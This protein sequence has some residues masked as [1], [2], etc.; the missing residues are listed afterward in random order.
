MR[1]SIPHS[2]PAMKENNDWAGNPFEGLDKSETCIDFFCEIHVTYTTHSCGNQ[3]RHHHRQSCFSVVRVLHRCPSKQLKKH[4]AD[5]CGIQEVSKS[6]I[7]QTVHARS[8]QIQSDLWLGN[9]L[10][11]DLRNTNSLN[12]TGKFTGG[13]WRKWH[14][15]GSLRFHWAVDWPPSLCCSLRVRE[16]LIGIPVI[17]NKWSYINAR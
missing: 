6:C 11:I 1:A 14:C 4:K 3:T 15:H 8:E 7:N 12:A 10:F 16:G 13:V 5:N 17:V 2:T 9:N